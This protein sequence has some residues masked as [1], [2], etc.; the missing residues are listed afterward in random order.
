MAKDAFQI[1]IGIAILTLYIYVS[2]CY[3]T[4][5]GGDSPEVIFV[6][7]VAMNCVDDDVGSTDGV[8]GLETR[9][10]TPTRHAVHTATVV[11]PFCSRRPV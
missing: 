3:P 11:S 7:F 4:V 5:A 10:T 1:V 8:D 9:R 2:T 6:L